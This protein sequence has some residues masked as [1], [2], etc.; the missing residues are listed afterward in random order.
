MTII[1]GTRVNCVFDW[2]GPGT[3]FAI[4][5]EQPES[6][7]QIGIA[8]FDV[9]FDTGVISRDVSESVIRGVQWSIL[10]EIV[11]QDEIAEALAYA[12]QVAADEKRAD[13]EYARRIA[14]EIERL[15]A[16]PA[17]KHLVRGDDRHSG[18]IAAQNI[19][20]ELKAA[21]PG[22]RFSVRNP[23]DGRVRV[24]WTDGP[25]EARV[26]AIVDKYLAFTFYPSG[27]FKD[28]DTD[29]VNWDHA[30]IQVF[31]A[32]DYLSTSRTH[33]DAHMARAIDA[34]FASHAGL[35]GIERPTPQT[36]FGVRVPVP[37]EDWDLAVLIRIKAAEMEGGEGAADEAQPG[38]GD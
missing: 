28:R 19:R 27:S 20:T 36:A 25:T 10:P 29:Q 32:T 23:H 21:F 30:W 31:G 34:L 12:E 6:V 15:R 37:G 24:A 18:K 7:R 35:K 38:E 5:G 17:Y 1:V 22:V 13:E 33:S 2:A 9:V 3:V 4:H 16:D 26:S 11:T 8:T 14:E